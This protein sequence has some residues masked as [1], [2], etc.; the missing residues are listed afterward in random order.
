MGYYA[1][2]I[3]SEASSSGIGVHQRLNG[4]GIHQFND[5]LIEGTEVTWND[6]RWIV[7][8]VDENHS[9]PSSRSGAHRPGELSLPAGTRTTDCRS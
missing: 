7:D 9:T 3:R 1:V 6:E 5:P 4:A 2:M 8:E